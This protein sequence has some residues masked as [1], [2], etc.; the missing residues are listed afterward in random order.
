MDVRS[1]VGYLASALQR[2]FSYSLTWI[3]QWCPICNIELRLM[4]AGEPSRASLYRQ[5]FSM[6]DDHR[7]DSRACAT[8]EAYE[9]A[10]LGSVRMAERAQAIQQLERVEP[11]RDAPSLYERAERESI[12]L[13]TWA[14]TFEQRLRAS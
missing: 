10:E 8:E 3:V 11:P 5:L 14:Q 6:Y 1:E 9:R 12:E 13:A 4:V 2:P 7:C